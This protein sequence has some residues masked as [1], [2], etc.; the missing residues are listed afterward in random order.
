VAE[1]GNMTRTAK[2]ARERQA[3]K[4]VRKLSMNEQLGETPQERK[5]INNI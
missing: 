4:L 5:N 2:L 1:A 3:L